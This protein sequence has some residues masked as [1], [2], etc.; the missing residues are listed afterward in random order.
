M[1]GLVEGYCS[2]W[3]KASWNFPCS[4]FIRQQAAVSNL[5]IPHSRLRAHSDWV[6]ALISSSSTVFPSHT[7][8]PPFRGCKP[9]PRVPLSPPHVSLLFPLLPA[10][11]RLHPVSSVCKPMS[12]PICRPM[13][14]LCCA[15]WPAC[16]I[17]FMWGWT[18]L[19][20]IINGETG[21]ST[22]WI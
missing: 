1:L 15:A 7:R 2:L 22:R 6:P 5:S 21:H 20:L 13:M 17:R 3:R 8:L 14:G 4:S 10:G 18:C 19:W 11:G 12:Q 16:E 9:F